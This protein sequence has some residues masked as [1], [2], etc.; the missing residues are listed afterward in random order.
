[1]HT[2]AALITGL[3]ATTCA[4]PF[5]IIK[6]R[7]M[8]DGKHHSSIYKGPIDCLFKTIQREG[9]RALWRGWWPAYCRLGPHAIMYVF[10]HHHYDFFYF[11]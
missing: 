6:T 9:F 4:A 3:V 10:H 8:N 11:F 1:M 5:D 2:A 7:S